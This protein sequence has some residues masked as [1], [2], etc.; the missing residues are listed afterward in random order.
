MH[1][2]KH[3]QI[4]GKFPEIEVRHA[5]SVA[6][7]GLLERCVECVIFLDVSLNKSLFSNRESQEEKEDVDAELQSRSQKTESMAVIFDENM[8]IKT[9]PF[10]AKEF[11]SSLVNTQ[12]FSVFIGSMW[13]E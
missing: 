11:I 10:Q 9:F 1:P 7:Y 12:A 6:M 8:F 2:E 4:F 3:T 5:F 13:R